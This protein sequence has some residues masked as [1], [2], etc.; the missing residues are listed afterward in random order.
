MWVTEA[1]L[2]PTLLGEAN[3]NFAIRSRH[4]GTFT[5]SQFDL[6]DATIKRFMSKGGKYD[7]EEAFIK[8]Y[9]ALVKEFGQPS[10]I[11]L[12]TMYN[13]CHAACAPK[14]LQLAMQDDRISHMHIFYF[15]PYG[16]EGTSASVAVMDGLNTQIQRPDG[17]VTK[18]TCTMLTSLAKGGLAQKRA[19]RA[20][21]AMQ[22]M[23]HAR[24]GPY[25]E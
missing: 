25:F 20:F 23:V 2:S 22:A 24:F 16:G 10:T 13:P 1:D 12:I 7:S 11:V 14:L 15:E 3:K 9:E 21:K 8:H 5:L 18:L 4:G 19:P 6:K 17:G